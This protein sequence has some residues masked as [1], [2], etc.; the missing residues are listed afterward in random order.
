[1]WE[2]EE[3]TRRYVEK[4]MEKWVVWEKKGME[5]KRDLERVGVDPRSAWCWGLAGLESEEP[6]YG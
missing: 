4:A 1:M 6:Y 3:G 2:E 5:N